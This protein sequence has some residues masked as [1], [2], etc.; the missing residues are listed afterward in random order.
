VDGKIFQFDNA[1]HHVNISTF[2]HHFHNG[3]EN[4]VVESSLSRAPE[5][6]VSQVKGFRARVFRAA[7]GVSLQI[8]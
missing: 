3:S 8:R 7:I 5:E 6:A 1:P 2:P 4:S